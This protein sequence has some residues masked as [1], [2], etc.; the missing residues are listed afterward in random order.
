MQEKPD[1]YECLDVEKSLSV[2]EIR[3][4]YIALA[5]KWH[6]DKNKL[7]RKRAEKVF[8][9]ISE[10]FFVLSNNVLRLIYDEDGIGEAIRN[11]KKYNLN[12]FSLQNALEVFNNAYRNRDPITACLED[13]NWYENNELFTGGLMKN[14]NIER[15]KGKNTLETE[16]IETSM[17]KYTS[18]PRS[19]EKTVKTV[20]VER[21]GKRVKKTITTVLRADGTQEIIEE[22]KEEPIVKLALHD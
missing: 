1:Y 15:F 10:A 6:P 13:E 14:K 16:V 3:K 9:E 8:I 17:S 19:V 11:C 2:D 22:E 5:L 7:G 4:S 18:S 20:I 12:E 21:G